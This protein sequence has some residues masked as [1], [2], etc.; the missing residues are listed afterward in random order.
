MSDTTPPPSD[1]VPTPP[2]A[3]PT[4][5][6]PAAATP[7]PPPPGAP[8]P[9]TYPTAPSAG[10]PGA[11][12]SNGMGTA[13]LIMGIL[14]FFCLPVIAGVLAI[15]FGKIGMNKA[16]AGEATNG[17]VAKA[18]FWLGIIGLILTVIA[19][20]V[21]IIL[22]AAGVAFVSNSVDVAKNSQTGLVDGNYG[23]NPNSSIRIN[24]RCAFDGAAVNIGQAERHGRRLRIDRVRHGH[25]HAGRR[26][27]HGDRRR[28]EDR[29]GQLRLGHDERGGHGRAERRRSAPVHRR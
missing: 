14:Q 9:T 13:A 4:P 27:L 12:P 17:G 6:P 16:K 24:D 2:P 8:A 29:R 7:P 1:P 18:G 21:T 15:V 22:I 26:D 20:I 3:E 10:M 19:G 28:R 23:M 25:G 11:A 5:T